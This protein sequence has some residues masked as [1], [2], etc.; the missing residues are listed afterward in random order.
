MSEHVEPRPDDRPDM[1]TPRPLGPEIPHQ[2]DPLP[3]PPRPEIPEQPEPVPELP[4][5]EIPT[6]DDPAP[7]QPPAHAAAMMFT[8]MDANRDGKLTMAEMQAGHA[9]MMGRKKGM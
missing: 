3:G 2:P 4:M 1:P 5:P 7:V 6:R 8:K 9:D